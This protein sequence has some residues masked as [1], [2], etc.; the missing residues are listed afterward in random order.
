[1]ATIQLT[2]D[3]DERT[4]EF[5][6]LIMAGYTGRNQSEVAAHVDELRAHGIPAPERVPMLYACA[7]ELL[8][9]AGQISVL[10]G[11]TSGEGEFVLFQDGVELLVGVGSDH[12]DRALEASDIPRAKQVCAK[13]VSREVWRVAEVIEGWDD[14][15]LRAWVGQD[16]SETLY[17]E[18]PLARMLTP[19]AILDYVGKQL[20]EPLGSAVVFS[21]TLSII[22]GAFQP[23]ATFA[24][25]LFD[26]RRERRL[27]CAYR[28]RRLDYLR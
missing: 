18:G 27:R 15:L 9:T 17:Q 4:F 20:T 1:M 5:D 6:K 12:T 24:V 8:T 23:S 10:G 21:G 14:L 7:P 2:L 16:G 3:G 28:A 13:I 19:Q 26:P 25:E 11:D 22:G